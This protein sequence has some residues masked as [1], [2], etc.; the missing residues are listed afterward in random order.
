MDLYNSKTGRTLKSKLSHLT[1][2]GILRRDLKD[3]T[4][5][6]DLVRKAP[7]LSANQWYWVH[8]LANDVHIG[9]PDLIIDDTE[10]RE[11]LRS[12]GKKLKRP[13]F[14]I[15]MPP[16]KDPEELAFMAECRQDKTVIPFYAD[17]LKENEDPRGELLQAYFDHF[18]GKYPDQYNFRGGPKAA[19]WLRLVFGLKFDAIV[20][21]CNSTKF[22]GQLAIVRSNSVVGYIVEG[23]VR[24]PK[25][26]IPLIEWLGRDTRGLIEICGKLCGHCCYC[27]IEL[28]HPKSIAAGY[29][30]KCASNYG[31]PWG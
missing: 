15:F 17:W 5:A 14:K 11:V 29:G 8:K 26:L 28:S 25:D 23:N 9:E 4:F 2:L 18:D 30:E 7:K 19:R 1:A 27:G 20:K 24:C 22:K 3:S 6:Q 13:K 10:I 16:T 31:M 21:I 12:G